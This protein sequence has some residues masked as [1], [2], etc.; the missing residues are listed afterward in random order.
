MS[1]KSHYAEDAGRGLRLLADALGMDAT[2][3]NC[4][5]EEAADFMPELTTAGT[6]RFGQF[7]KLLRDSVE[8]SKKPPMTVSEFEALSV[9]A[10]RG[11]DTFFTPP[12][13]KEDE[14]RVWKW[15]QDD[16][17]ASQWLLLQKTERR[18]AII[19]R[20][21]SRRMGND[22]VAI[23]EASFVEGLSNLNY[24]ESRNEILRLRREERQIRKEKEENGKG[25]G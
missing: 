5:E 16:G 2:E 20:E 14:A 9:K 23:P 4:L 15:T 7:V 8:K 24:E 11:A 25:T 10:R 19:R 22:L 6:L 18:Y 17:N 13:Q 3:R 12:D 21:V 1:A